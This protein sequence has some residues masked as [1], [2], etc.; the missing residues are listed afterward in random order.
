MHHCWAATQ[1]GLETMT[2]AEVFD[3]GIRG[4]TPSPGGVA[5]RASTRQLYLANMWLRT[6]SRVLVRAGRFQASSFA[7]LQAGAAR[8]DWSAWLGPGTP[9][10]FRV[11]THSSQL[12]HTTAIAQRLADAMGVVIADPAEDD[13]QLIVGRM[14]DDDIS[15]SVDSSGAHLHRRGWRTDVGRA[16]MRET[17]GAALVTASGWDASSGLLDPLCGSGTIPI[18]AALMASGRAPGA[19]RRF[20]FQRWPSLE[21][22]TWASVTG[23]A[24]AAIRQ[25]TALIVASDRDAGAI[26]A[27][28]ANAERAGVADLIETRRT[29]LSNATHPAE[30]GWV[31]T[32]PPY[33]KRVGGP[34]LR[35]LYARLGQRT[36]RLGPGWRLALWHPDVRLAGHTG[37]RFRDALTTTN[38]GIRIHALIQREP[39]PAS[40]P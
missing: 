4:P 1:P 38:G 6:A 20:A 19:N 36:A 29:A 15:L 24:A 14:V 23:G 3:L 7:Q 21:P 40:A 30:E 18:E 8:I 13:A 34:D 33:G 35:D 31:L 25:P 9:V 10:R 26:A 27:T 11:T 5:F 16:P 17:L 39:N 12:Y 37:V 22:G 32:N 28:R 2:A